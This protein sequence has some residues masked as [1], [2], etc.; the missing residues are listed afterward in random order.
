MHNTLFQLLLSSKPVVRKFPKYRNKPL[1]FHPVCSKFTKRRWSFIV[2]R[3]LN[4][5]D[6]F[7]TIS[8]NIDYSRVHQEF[9]C[10]TICCESAH[11]I[12]YV[13]VSNDVC[14]DVHT[15]IFK[16]LIPLPSLAVIFM[17]KFMKVYIFEP[18]HF[19]FC[20]GII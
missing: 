2:F 18:R 9:E 10:K 14:L 16:V 17:Q 11:E 4:Q 8:Y 3:L 19:N 20:R 1:F 13:Q 15:L 6:F 7:G 5:S 12:D